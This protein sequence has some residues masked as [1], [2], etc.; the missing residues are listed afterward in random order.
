MMIHSSLSKGTG[1]T[2]TFKHLTSHVGCFPYISNGP[3]M[4]G[5][6]RVFGIRG[7][8]CFL[9]IAEWCSRPLYRARLAT[10]RDRNCTG[11]L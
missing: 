9:G 5:M 8:S 11:T 7:G 4:W 1:E 2:N 3:L 10:R 6:Y